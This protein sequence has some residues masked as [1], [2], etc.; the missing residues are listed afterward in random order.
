MKFLD[1]TKSPVI[2]VELSLPQIQKMIQRE[3]GRELRFM[4]SLLT[5]YY[6]KRFKLIRFPSPIGFSVAAAVDIAKGLV[7]F[8][9]GGDTKKVRIDALMPFDNIDYLLYLCSPDG[10]ALESQAQH[11]GDLGSLAMHL[12]DEDFLKKIGVDPKNWD[13]IQQKNIAAVQLGDDISTIYYAAE[14][15]IKAN[16]LLGYSYGLTYWTKLGISPLFIESGGA[17]YKIIDLKSYFQYFQKIRVS[18]L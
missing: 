2:E 12:P 1:L 11:H 6:H 16:T 10:S 5:K 17:P 9:Y 14:C 3:T 4:N 18:F 8:P 13:N 7:L 15:D